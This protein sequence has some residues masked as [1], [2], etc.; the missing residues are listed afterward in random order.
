MVECLQILT[1]VTLTRPYLQD[2]VF[3]NL[4]QLKHVPLQENN[5]NFSR[6]ARDNIYVLPHLSC[7][8][9]GMYKGFTW[10]YFK[11]TSSCKYENFSVSVISVQ[12]EL[13]Q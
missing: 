4:L 11:T 2:L 12:K 5:T 1:K 10:K 7:D 6:L 3:T 8:L 9:M 13:Q